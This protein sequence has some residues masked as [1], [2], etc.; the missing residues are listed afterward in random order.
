MTWTKTKSG[1]LNDC[2]TQSPVLL[3]LNTVFFLYSLAHLLVQILL[4]HS[5][6]NLDLDLDSSLFLLFPLQAIS[7]SYQTEWLLLTSSVFLESAPS[8]TVLYLHAPW[9]T[10]CCLYFLPKSQP[11]SRP[12]VSSF[13]LCFSFSQ[14]IYPPQCRRCKMSSSSYVFN[15]KSINSLEHLDGAVS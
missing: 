5:S 7:Q 3:F 12:S 10:S 14:R 1:M 9:S 15:Q 11:F 2:V 6:G 4:D 8:S 13:P